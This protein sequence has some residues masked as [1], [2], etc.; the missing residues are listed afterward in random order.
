M[1]KIILTMAIAVLALT[2][3]SITAKKPTAGLAAP[4]A[5]GAGIFGIGKKKVDPAGETEFLKTDDGPIPEGAHFVRLVNLERPEE[6]KTMVIEKEVLIGREKS[7]DLVLADQSVSRKQFKIDSELYI[8]NLSASNITA[9]NDSPLESREK[10][11]PGDK[12]TCGRT[13]LIV[14]DCSLGKDG[15]SKLN[16]QTKFLRI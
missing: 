3:M 11:K 2:C 15:M 16:S 8:E 9:L 1:K 6:S 5:L 13:V 10:I 7:C 14:E 4:Y 12:I